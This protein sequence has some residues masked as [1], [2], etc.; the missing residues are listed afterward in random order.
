MLMMSRIQLVPVSSRQTGLR[1]IDW[2]RTSVNNLGG[3]LH[4][5]LNF[6][7]SGWQD[8]TKRPPVVIGDGCEDT[9]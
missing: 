3:T 8:V 7:G 1:R 9:G 6:V 4:A 5:G 2:L